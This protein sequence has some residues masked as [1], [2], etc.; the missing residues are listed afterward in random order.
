MA[1][2]K[3]GNR[4]QWGGQRPNAGRPSGLRKLMKF[5]DEDA[6]TI[7]QL[8]K[9]YR[10]LLGKPEMS[11]EEMLMRLANRDWEEIM[12][13]YEPAEEMQEPYIL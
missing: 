8:T 13:A 1:T 6:K 2:E 10:N 4:K 5:K 9:Y 12:K 3:Q 11:Q 7:Y